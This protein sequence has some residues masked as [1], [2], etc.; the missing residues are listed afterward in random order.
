MKNQIQDLSNLKDA[1]RS[2]SPPKLGYKRVYRGQTKNFDK[3]LSSACRPDGTT[4]G[5][6]WKLALMNIKEI[7]ELP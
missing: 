2:L 7:Y 4:K 3:M 6:L 5:F 1:I